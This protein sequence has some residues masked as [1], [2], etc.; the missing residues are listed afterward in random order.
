MSAFLVTHDRAAHRMVELEQERHPERLQAVIDGMIR[1]FRLHPDA[2]VQ[3]VAVYVPAD[4]P[5][6]V[7]EAWVRNFVESRDP[8]SGGP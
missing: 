3:D 8:D 6:E 7:A 2:P 5:D 4:L 1:E